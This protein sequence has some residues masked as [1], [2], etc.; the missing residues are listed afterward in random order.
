MSILDEDDREFPFGYNNRDHPGNLWN[1]DPDCIAPVVCS[2]CGKFHGYCD[3]VTQK[4][5][6]TGEKTMSLP[7]PQAKAGG[8]RFKRRPFLKGKDIKSKGVT[9]ITI[10]A[11][12][13]APKA[14]ENADVLVDVKIGSKEFTWPLAFSKTAYRVLYEKFGKD[15]KKW[16]GTVKAEQDT[17]LGNAF[18]RLVE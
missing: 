15:E 6:S 14:F 9:Q 13:E 5:N 3:T 16:K 2:G 11:V 18:V 17:Y 8:G 4:L 12:R 1:T 10:E 7:A